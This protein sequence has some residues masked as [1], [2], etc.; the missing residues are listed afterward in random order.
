MDA[1]PS[2]PF[3]FVGSVMVLHLL[4]P[5]ITTAL[6][7]GVIVWAIRRAEPAREDPAVAELKARLARSEIDPIDYQVRMRAL[8]G[9]DD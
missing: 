4:T 3:R 5:V 7:L 8:R 9:G 2:D 1:L 6:I